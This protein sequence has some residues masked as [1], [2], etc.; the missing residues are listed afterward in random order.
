VS[1]L[2]D[3]IGYFDERLLFFHDR[4]PASSGK[5]ELLTAGARIVGAEPD[6]C[7]Y[8]GDQPGDAVAAEKADMRFLGVTYGWGLSRQDGQHAYANTIAEIPGKL[9]ELLAER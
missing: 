7:V 5:A 9:K 8:I 2:G 6:A 3:A 4:Y 1:A